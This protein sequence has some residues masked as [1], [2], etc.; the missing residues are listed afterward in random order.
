MDRLSQLRRDELR[1]ATLAGI[2][3]RLGI[4]VKCVLLSIALLAA[5]FTRSDGVWQPL[6]YV[7]FGILFSGTLIYIYLYR[8]SSP[9]QLVTIMTLS[10]C[11]EVFCISLIYCIFVRGYV[12]PVVFLFFS[13][14]ILRLIL[15]YPAVP[16]FLLAAGSSSA[17]FLLV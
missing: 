12:V 9:T 3:K 5:W 6:F 13:L 1:Y 16:E 2:E 11:L 4:A 8:R 15:F 14:P 10:G 17:V 7:Y